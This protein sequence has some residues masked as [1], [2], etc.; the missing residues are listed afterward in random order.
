MTP[1]RRKTITAAAL[2]PAVLLVLLEIIPRWGAVLPLG[3]VTQALVTLLVFGV[4][5][6]VGLGGV[7]ARRAGVA[8][9]V[10]GWGGFVLAFA[11]GDMAGS[12]VHN[13]MARDLRYPVPD[14]SGGTV[15][16]RSS[17][18]DAVSVE[19]FTTREGLV[20]VAGGEDPASIPRSL[21]PDGTA[22]MALMLG[23]IV[24]GAA[25]VAYV[26]TGPREDPAGSDNGRAPEGPDAPPPMSADDADEKDGDR[27][28][29]TPDRE[30][31]DGQET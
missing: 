3:N 21:L 16:T 29:D 25:S 31:D 2:V 6:Y 22:Q 19:H 28:P 14:S 23:W 4:L 11:V 1:R 12:A 17:S 26:R 18:V 7:A 20:S 30:K 5:V 9:F 13:E 24:A 27:A 8:L 10:L 15:T